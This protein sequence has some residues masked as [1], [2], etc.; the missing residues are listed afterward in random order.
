MCAKTDK[1][2]KQIL[3]F[4]A[5]LSSG[6]AIMGM[7]LGLWVGSMVIV[8]DG[9]YSL[10]SLLLTLLSLTAAWYIRQ[11]SDFAKSHGRTIIQPAVIAIKAM[12]ILALVSVS[13]YAAIVAVMNGGREVDASIATLFGVI[14]VI[15]CGYAWWFIAR[16]GKKYNSPLV[17]AEA[18]QWQMDALISFAVMAGFITAWIME[19]TPWAQYANYADPL[20]VLAMSVY[21]VKVPLEMLIQACRDLVVNAQLAK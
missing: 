11:G 6:F 9:V 5:V 18:A 10:I 19:I 14:N 15:G 17:N 3:T 1:N 20:M 7:V 13:I 16:R 8:F 21:F 12:V 4:S 2:E